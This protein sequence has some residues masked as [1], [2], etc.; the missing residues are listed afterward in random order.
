MSNM[1]VYAST[2]SIILYL[3][4]ATQGIHDRD[5]DRNALFLSRTV[6]IL[7]LILYSLWLFWRHRTHANLFDSTD[8]YFLG[9]IDAH[10]VENNAEGNKSML[11]PLPAIII[12]LVCIL[13]IV[14]CSASLVSSMEG[15]SDQLQTLM[16]V[17]VVPII[18]RLGKHTKAVTFAVRGNPDY[19]ADLSLGFSLHV[20]L[21]LGPCL[22]IA[23]WIIGQPMTLRF[24]LVET[25]V[26]GITV[27]VVGFIV[28][29]G[30]S[31]YLDGFQLLVM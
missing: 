3:F 1:T 17:L 10:G 19:A 16:G 5:I 28:A 18:L 6:A 25:V 4:Q 12:S 29:N 8:K 13:P 2:L 24:G 20:V 27:W 31:N 15:R 11:A 14:M 21:F 26:Y 7:L 22:V 30:K 23:G 9:E